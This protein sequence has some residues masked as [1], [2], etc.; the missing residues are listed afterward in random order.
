MANAHLVVFIE[1][2]ARELDVM[3]AVRHLLRE[4]HG[5]ELAVRST[6]FDLYEGMLAAGS[7][8]V[9][10]FP[11]FY[12][13]DDGP[14]RRARKLW[15][16]ARYVNLAW[17]QVL[18]NINESVKTPHGELA[19]TQVRHFAWGD[20]YRDLLVRYGVRAELV[21]VVGNP[22]YGLYTEPYRRY[23]EDKPTLAAR[24]GLD[25]DKPWLLVAENYGAAF[26]PDSHL[27][28]MVARGASR[29]ESW[30]FREFARA[31]LRTMCEWLRDL[32]GPSL[33]IVLRPRPYTPRERFMGKLREAIGDPPPGL[34][35]IQDGSVREWILASDAVVSSYSTSL[36]E[37]AI[38]E[39]PIAMLAPLPL[40]E[41]VKHPWYEYVPRFPSLGELRDFVLSGDPTFA[42]LRQWATDRMLRTDPIR[43]MADFLAATYH[44]APSVSVSPAARLDVLGRV[45]SRSLKKA[46]G[47]RPDKAA[48]H[49]RF[50]QD[51]VTA[52]TARWAGLA[53]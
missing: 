51:E 13:D 19:R 27:E 46:M 21:T 6:K 50:G 5:L 52:R 23:F 48:E 1:H 40:P 25:P 9:V 32:A 35:V 39:K 31:S 28:V 53:P 45:A 33:E 38:A 11:W 43:G 37:A 49:D 18:Q 44:D 24:H 10:A 4:R 30:G 20:F 2:V 47:R 26:Y 22:V 36:I 29:E 42:A 41:F 8:R 15:P 34:R 3:C 14:I 16:D 7:P 17:E 12:E